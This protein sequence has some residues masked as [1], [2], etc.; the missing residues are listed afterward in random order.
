MDLDSELLAI[1]YLSLPEA[2]DILNDQK[3]EQELVR[4]Y[5]LDY[6]SFDFLLTT[7]RSDLL[8]IILEK[9]IINQEVTLS[10]KNLQVL[11]RA[12]SELETKI[13][14]SL[15]YAYEPYTKVDFVKINI[16]LSKLS[17]LRI[18]T[19]NLSFEIVPE[20]LES[21]VTNSSIKRLQLTT[22]E[23]S[24]LK[25]ISRILEY[26]TILESLDIPYTVQDLTPIIFGLQQNR[27]LTELGIPLN[28]DKNIQHGHIFFE[29]LKQNK[30]LKALNLYGK[31][32]RE[33]LQYLA[34]LLSINQS[35]TS[36]SLFEGYRNRPDFSDAH[37]IQLF[38]QSLT[39]NKSINKLRLEI[40]F[41]NH[42]TE[43]LFC[44]SIG[45][46]TDLDMTRSNLNH[47][48]ME[49]LAPIISQSKTLKRLSLRDNPI[50][51]QGLILVANAMAQNKSITEL[52]LSVNWQEMENVTQQLA[53]HAYY[54]INRFLI[55]NHTLTKFIF[56]D[57]D[58][59]FEADHL[60]HM[61]NALIR[62][63]ALTSLSLE[64]CN[65]EHINPICD[66]ILENNILTELNLAWN[67]FSDQDILKL[68]EALDK[69]NKLEKINLSNINLSKDLKRELQYNKRITI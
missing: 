25:Y 65:L 62:N 68:L 64:S 13:D 23:N 56:E 15:Y 32:S 20:L 9:N 50:R 44:H 22:T 40:A 66:L 58:F 53:Y 28:D 38:C 41:P 55:M 37:S 31:M 19:S 7:N 12:F 46:I 27:T 34:E 51:N 29:S 4:R 8:K 43:T 61:S 3:S 52:D 26:N 48:S 5:Y 2:L 45:N 24:F 67:H 47:Q 39:K 57:I 36:L 69:N 33:N 18:I 1:S 21:I 6:Q 54:P 49:V 14:F 11:S 42:Q 60:K 10:L 30:T 59:S 16:I 17:S 63:I 35:L